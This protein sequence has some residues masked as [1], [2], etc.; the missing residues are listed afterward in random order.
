MPPFYPK[1]IEDLIDG[2]TIYLQKGGI[3]HISKPI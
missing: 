2:K 3:A 1:I